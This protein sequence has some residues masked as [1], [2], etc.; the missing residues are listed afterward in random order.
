MEL[1]VLGAAR[2][3]AISTLTFKTMVWAE[4][5]PANNNKHAAEQINIDFLII[6]PSSLYEGL[7]KDFTLL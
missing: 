7:N 6:S 1:L 4:R 2:R 3:L 5:E